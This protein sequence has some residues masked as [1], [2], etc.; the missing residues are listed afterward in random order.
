MPSQNMTNLSILSDI[1]KRKLFCNAVWTMLKCMHVEKR[2]N[3]WEKIFIIIIMSKTPIDTSQGIHC[4][5]LWEIFIWYNQTLYMWNSLLPPQ[6]TQEKRRL[7]S[8]LIRIIQN[9]SR[10]KP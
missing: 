4:T 1:E 6:R 7:K 5:I 8:R 10:S 3:E 2:W 9:N